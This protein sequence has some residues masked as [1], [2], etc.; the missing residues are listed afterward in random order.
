MKKDPCPSSKDKYPGDAENLPTNED[1]TT[2]TESS[3]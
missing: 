3:R 2:N 1:P